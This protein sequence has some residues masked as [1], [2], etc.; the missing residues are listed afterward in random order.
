MKPLSP[1]RQDFFVAIAMLLLCS[2][3]TAQASGFGGYFE[4]G[5]VDGEI[6]LFSG[7]A[8]DVDFDAN[9]F[10]VGFVYDSNLAGDSLFNYRGTFGYRASEHTFDTVLG[11]L[12]L[13]ADGFEMNHLFGF[14]IVRT[15]SMR[16]FI[17][18]A[19]RI[20]V[21]VFDTVSGVDLVNVDFGIGPEIGVN[22]HL[23]EHLTLSPWVS[24]QYHYLVQSV[25]IDGLGNDAFSGS[26]H[27]VKVGMSI[28]F[29][30]ADDQYRR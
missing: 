12:E 21:D 4:Y 18:P 25:D 17:G 3:G 15:D 28:F 26:E 29:R 14:G 7:G 1:V 27:V 9:Q 16:I 5:S 8:G 30:T 23:S 22:L 6:E 11:D 13:D 19:I 10:G 2:A 20:G 24:Y